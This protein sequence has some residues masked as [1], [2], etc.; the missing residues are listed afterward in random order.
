[1]KRCFIGMVFLALAS[2]KDDPAPKE[3]VATGTPGR[4]VELLFEQD[5]CRVYRFYDESYAR[6]FVVCPTG[7]VVASQMEAHRHSNGKT[8]YTQYV[9]NDIPT[10]H[11]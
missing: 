8:S 2:C 1:M 10:V 11:R 4:T 5:A 6:Y 9:P 3:I 7:T